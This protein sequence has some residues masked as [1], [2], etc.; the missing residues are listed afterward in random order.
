MSATRDP[1]RETESEEVLVGCRWSSPSESICPA[2]EMSVTWVYMGGVNV[3][4]KL[5]L[6]PK[7]EGHHLVLLIRPVRLGDSDPTSQKSNNP[8]VKPENKV[9]HINP[10]QQL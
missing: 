10:G 7:G 1:G 3:E 2:C 6:N 9:Q 4:Q 8:G 5:H